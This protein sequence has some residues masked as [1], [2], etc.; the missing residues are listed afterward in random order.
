MKQVKN[1][2]NQKRVIEFGSA[3]KSNFDYKNTYEFD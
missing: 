2:L 1:F 3:G